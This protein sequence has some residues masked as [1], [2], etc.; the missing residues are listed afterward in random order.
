VNQE[1][2]ALFDEDQADRL[3]QLPADLA[4]RDQRRRRRVEQLLA[5]GTVVDPDDLFHAAMVFQHGAD[6]AHFLRAHELSKRA[7]ELG[8][9]RPVRWLAAAA[10]DR[11]LMTGGL[12]QKYGTQYRFANGRWILHE[13]DPAT[14][15]EERA[16]W[17]VPSLTETLRRADQMTCDSGPRPVRVEST[18]D[19]AD[20]PI[21]FG[22][23]QA[24]WGPID[25]RFELLTGEVDPGRIARVFVVP[26]IGSACVVVGFEHGDWGPAGGGLEPG[27]S[28]QAAL[29][30]ELAEEAGGRLQIYTPFAV[31]HCHSRAGGPYRPQEPHP[32]YDC[33]Y[34]YGEVELVGPPQLHAG[35]ERT[36][37]VEVMPPDEAA[38][39]L[40]GKGRAWEADLYR[41]AAERRAAAPQPP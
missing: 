37:A 39:F 38:S 22:T 2:R 35:P 11:W 4:E 16:R 19:E 28:F 18:V 34:G 27:E 33:L 20:Y 24:T 10:Y 30:R 14:S 9:T 17:D 21:L 32:D 5:E 3:G 15:D 31:L 6:R 25:L 1:L 41:L 36:V 29:E 7:A 13:V 12:P 40:A 23:T 8:S 26:F